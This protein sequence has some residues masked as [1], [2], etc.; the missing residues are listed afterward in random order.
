[1]DRPEDGE[2]S[3]TEPVAPRILDEDGARAYLGGRNPWSV[4]PPIRLGGRNCW[5]RVALDQR[6]DSLFG[7]VR[8]AAPGAGESPLD[9]WRKGKQGGSENAA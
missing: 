5:D 7:V 6:L 3:L 9:R 4:M 8:D 2:E 1:V